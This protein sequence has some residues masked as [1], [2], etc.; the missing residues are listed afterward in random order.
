MT[1]ASYVAGPVVDHHC[2]GLVLRDLDRPSFEA[3]MNEGAGAGRWTGS[4]FDSMLGVAIRRHC[5][6]LLGLEPHIDAD[7]YL[8][9]RLAIGH[10]EVARRMLGAA[11]IDT[12]LVDT[13]FLPD[14]ICSPAEVAA[15]AGSTTRSHEIAR[16][17]TIAQ[18]LLASGT[19]IGDLLSAVGPA[20]RRSPRRSGPRASRRTAAASTC[21]ASGRATSTSSSRW[22]RC[23][24]TTPGRTESPTGP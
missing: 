12:L 2:H 5:A 6:P 4:P 11:E 9:R 13:G 1:E 8:A 10:E 16:L 14:D 17:E 24:P 23:G 3:L 7:T 20:A 22:G 18:D 15:L 21:P 19:A